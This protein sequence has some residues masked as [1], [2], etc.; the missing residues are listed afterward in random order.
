MGLNLETLVGILLI[1]ILLIV[2]DGLRRAWRERQSRLRLKIDTRYSRAAEV[3]D[4]PDL[5]NPELPGGGARP[6]RR[7]DQADNPG[8]QKPPVI[9]EADDTPAPVTRAEQADLFGDDE[10]DLPK[11]SA[12]PDEELPARRPAVRMPA[13]EPAAPATAAVKP[14]SQQPVRESAG[15]TTRATRADPPAD[16]N[17][18]PATPREVLEVIVVHMIAPSGARF[19]GR[20][21]LQHLLE[22]GL[23]F[24]EMNIFH[25]HQNGPDGAELLFSMANAVEPGTFDIDEMEKQQFAGVTFFL[26]LPGPSRPVEALD[27]MLDVVR[28]LAKTLDGELRDEQRSVLTPQT[29]EHLRQRV[30]EFDRRQRLAH[31]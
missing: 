3:E 10:D 16:A 4:D 11:I 24:G 21:L 22:Q 19:P 14:A 27:R 20:D 25:C 12:L 8:Q 30:Q 28:H 31:S 5:P 26:K 2:A 18:R 7:A 15:H 13:E 17:G 9:M 6:V 23:R 29:M 1:L